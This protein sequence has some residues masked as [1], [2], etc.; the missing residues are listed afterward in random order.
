M[1]DS[2]LRLALAALAALALLA[3]TGCDCDS[4]HERDA[5]APLA[6]AGPAV[7]AGGPAV[8]AGLPCVPDTV[9]CADWDARAA[10]LPG[11]CD[12]PCPFVAPITQEC[13]DLLGSLNTC[14]RVTE[15]AL[16]DPRCTTTCR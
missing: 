15:A 4:T 7:D 16:T 9:A 3:L 8:D 10:T 2:T 6:D 11:G 5:G 14:E 1:T 12:E 13:A